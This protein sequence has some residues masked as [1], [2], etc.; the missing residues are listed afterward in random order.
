MKGELNPSSA[1]GVV[2][3]RFDCREGVPSW[4]NVEKLF[5]STVLSN[6]PIRAE[7]EPQVSCS[8]P[9]DTA[10]M[11][12]EMVLSCRELGLFRSHS[13]LMGERGPT[14]EGAEEE[15]VEEIEGATV[16]VVLFDKVSGL[17]V[18]IWLFFE[19]ETRQFFSVPAEII[20]DLL[21]SNW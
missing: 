20:F 17:S 7:I 5:W 10:S 1:L 4:D 11:S 6:C 3:L 18:L 15:E 13:I 14:E 9:K 12:L 16:N 21:C 8:L 19:G 2:G